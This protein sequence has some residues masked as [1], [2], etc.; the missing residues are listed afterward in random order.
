MAAALAASA[1][2]TLHRFDRGERVKIATTSTVGSSSPNHES[3]R[4]DTHIESDPKKI[5]ASKKPMTLALREGLASPN[6]YSVALNLKAMRA[7]GSFA[8]AKAI[9][10]SCLKGTRNI[11]LLKMVRSEPGPFKSLAILLPSPD[12]STEALRTAAIQKIEARCSEFLKNP[13]FK[14]A[15]PDDPFGTE[16]MKV[17]HA[18]KNPHLRLDED[19]LDIALQQGS[20]FEL[21]PQLIDTQLKTPYFDGKPYGGT[22]PEVFRDAMLRATSAAYLPLD[23]TNDLRMLNLCIEQLVCNG[24]IDKLYPGINYRA[25]LEPEI[26]ALAARISAGLTAGNAKSFL[27]P[28][29]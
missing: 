14:E 22:S 18:A 6:P 27:A 9:F 25:D 2:F 23:K 24:D 12:P 16:Y 20:I 3:P 21:I 29:R 26:A 17:T 7:P 4:Q 1:I 13:E 11:A 28:Q 19:V 5:Q 15:Y 8:A 10:E